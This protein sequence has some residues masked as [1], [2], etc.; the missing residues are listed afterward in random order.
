MGSVTG[1]GSETDRDG[2]RQ[3]WDGMG[4]ETDKDG[5][6]SET[7]TWMGWGVRQTGM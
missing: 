6:G 5:M 4:S 2:D 3:G 1:T 7:K